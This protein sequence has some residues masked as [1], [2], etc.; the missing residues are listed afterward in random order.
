MS[1]RVP[2]TGVLRRKWLRRKASAF[3]GIAFAAFGPRRLQR[4]GAVRII[5]RFRHRG[6]RHRHRLDRAAAHGPAPR[7][8]SRRRSPPAPLDQEDWR[9]A[10]AALA[11]ALDPQG[12]GGAARWENGDNGHKGPFAPVGNAFLIKDDICRTFVSSLSIDGPEQWLQGTAC[13]VSPTE[14]TIKTVA[15]WKRPG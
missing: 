3:A 9:R 12:N 14:W 10:Q 13:R 7:P 6:G 15:T 4:A 5:A 2:L 11:T 1:G 8:R